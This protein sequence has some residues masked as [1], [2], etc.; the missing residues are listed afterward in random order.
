MS[1]T[2]KI[3]FYFK[4]SFWRYD[5]EKL[6][7]LVKINHNVIVAY[8]EKEIINNLPNIDI[9]ICSSESCNIIDLLFNNDPNF[10]KEKKIIFIRTN[11]SWDILHVNNKYIKENINLKN[12]YLLLNNLQFDKSG[13]NIDLCKK[14]PYVDVLHSYGNIERM[15]VYKCST[16]PKLE[17]TEFYKK[18]NLDINKKIFTI[19]L[20]FPKNYDYTQN[21]L[22]TQNESINNHIE[23][24]I[25]NNYTII[26]NIIKHLQTNYNVVFKP[27]PLHGMKFKPFKP[28]D[29]W[30]R[31][32]R[33]RTAISLASMKFYIDKYPFIEMGDGHDLNIYTKLGMIFSRST[34]CFSNYLFNIPLLYISNKQNELQ[35]QLTNE[36]KDKYDLNKICYGEFTTIEKLEENTSEILNN[37][38]DNFKDTPKFEFV[39]GNVLYG[40]TYNHDVKIWVD[41]INR[42]IEKPIK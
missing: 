18:Y 1:K 37:F 39:N 23:T 7:E 17:K 28:G 22:Y 40:D 27:H 25:C 11:T 10:F 21:Q 31:I 2:I 8:N 35:N 24:Y 6:I 33:K 14:R 34:F 4:E 42:I 38:I 19:Y 12:I 26:E 9:L 36:L 30:E 29:Y 41:Y 15:P 13:K 20:S 16:K 32:S 5:T 3:L